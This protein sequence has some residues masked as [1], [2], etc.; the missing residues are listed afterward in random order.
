MHLV[1]GHSLIP[2]YKDFIANLVDDSAKSD[3]NKVTSNYGKVSV[4]ISN[5]K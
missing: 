1:K 3:I 4:R 2:E 5:F